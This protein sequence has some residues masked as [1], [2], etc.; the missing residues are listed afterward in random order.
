MGRKGKCKY[1]PLLEDSS[2]GYR[3]PGLMAHLHND[4]QTRRLTP[5]GRETRRLTPGG[6]ETRRLTPGDGGGERDQV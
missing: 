2:A 3:N 5:G 6:G 1:G 4:A